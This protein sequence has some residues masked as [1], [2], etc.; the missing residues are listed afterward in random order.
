MDSNDALDGLEA[1]TIALFKG[2][3]RT[4]PDRRIARCT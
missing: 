1:R 3:D 4:G 2:L